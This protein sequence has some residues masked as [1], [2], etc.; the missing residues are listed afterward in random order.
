L[1]GHLYVVLSGLLIFLFK[2]RFD[3]IDDFFGFFQT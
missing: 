1:C 3:P 2:T